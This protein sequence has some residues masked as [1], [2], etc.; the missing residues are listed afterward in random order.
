MTRVLSSTARSSGSGGKLHGS[1][2]VWNSCESFFASPVPESNV[3]K[4]SDEFS[5]EKYRQNSQAS[6]ENGLPVGR[7][8]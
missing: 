6:F 3:G 8:F 5:S 7:P 1:G 2:E 4:M